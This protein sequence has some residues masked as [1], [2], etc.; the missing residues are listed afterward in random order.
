MKKILS[1]LLSTF[2]IFPVF[3]QNSL[4]WEIESEDGQKSYLFGTYHLVGS[5]YLDSHPKVEKAYSAASTVVVETMI[6]STK[7]LQVTMAGMMP[8]NSLR[9]L[10]D[11]TDY[12]FL[13]EKVEEE[14]GMDIALFDKM[15]PMTV[16]IMYSVSMAQD[17]T[18][19]KFNFA[20][21]PIDL[22]FAH[23]GKKQGKEVLQLETM[24]EQADI[25]YNSSTVEEQMNIL[26][27]MIR[28]EDGDSE[29]AT[30]EELLEAYQQ[31]DLARL[32]KM[33]DDMG[34]N[35]GDM[36]VLVDDRN[37]KWI[38]KLKPV[39]DK[40]DAFIAVGALHLPGKEGLLKLLEKEGYKLRAIE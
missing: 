13:K 20:G 12:A 9:N 4:L 32:Q 18:T 14:L 29:V 35:Y 30:A 34:S 26:I 19:E 38:G 2:L 40:G 28:E 21:Q 22:F 37:N 1:T 31:E 23:D 27:E 11:S 10:A 7:L 36:S 25:L 5:E 33:S 3:S 15:K 16:A 39:L 8:D 17:V 24:M 6:D